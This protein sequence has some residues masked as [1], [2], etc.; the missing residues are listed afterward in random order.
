M[1][2]LMRHMP[3]DREAVDTDINGLHPAFGCR[4][5]FPGGHSCWIAQSGR[6][7]NSSFVCRGFDSRSILDYSSSNSSSIRRTRAVCKGQM[8]TRPWPCAQRLMRVARQRGWLG[9]QRAR[10]APAASRGCMHAICMLPTRTAG[11]G[12]MQ[13]LRPPLSL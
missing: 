6:A 12:S 5:R 1:R 13:V 2:R 9:A 4:V 11:P 3:R 7:T 10:S 8:W